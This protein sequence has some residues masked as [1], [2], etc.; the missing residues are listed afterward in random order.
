MLKALI[1]VLIGVVLTLGGASTAAVAG[2]G[3][4][5]VVTM[6]SGE[7][8]LLDVESSDSIENV[9]QKVQD[10][11]LILPSE[12]LLTFGGTVLEDGRT[13]ADYSI[14]P[15]SSVTLGYVRQLALVTPTFPRFRLNVD[16]TAS[17]NASPAFS[18]LT[19]AVTAGAIPAGVNFDTA[20]GVFAGRPTTAGAYAFTITV[21]RDD[22]TTLVIPFAGTIAALPI[23]A[24]PADTLAET[25]VDP[26]VPLGL[27]VVL[28]LVGVSSLLRRSRRA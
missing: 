18:P 10:K 6:P 2:M 13:I 8:I 24:A 5:I 28:I 11:T 15:G 16:Y 26:L 14:P 12:Q 4:Q 25:G 23:A 9:R 22:A 20:T 17:I 21:T 19:F 3:M 27:A 1:A 7:T